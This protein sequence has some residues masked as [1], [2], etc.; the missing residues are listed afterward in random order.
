MVQLLESLITNLLILLIRGISTQ[1]L[2]VTWSPDTS[3]TNPQYRCSAAFGESAGDGFLS[4]MQTT[5]IGGYIII[6]VI[7]T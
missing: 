7:S 5:S 4:N 6:I 2:H 3:N 1:D